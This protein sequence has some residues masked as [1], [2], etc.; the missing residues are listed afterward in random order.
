MGGAALLTGILG[1]KVRRVNLFAR[2]QVTL[3][4]T[5]NAEKLVVIPRA[6]CSTS[7]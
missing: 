4:G 1:K 5:I 6:R 7:L 2:D 3:Q